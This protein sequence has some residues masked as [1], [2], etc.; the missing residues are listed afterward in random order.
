[1]QTLRGNDFWLA[2]Q[3]I[4]TDPTSWRLSIETSFCESKEQEEKVKRKIYFYFFCRAAIISISIGFTDWQTSFFTKRQKRG[5]IFDSFLD[6]WS[7]WSEL[8]PHKPWNQL[9]KLH[10]AYSFL[11]ALFTLFW[12]KLWNQSS[13]SMLMAWRDF[14]IESGVFIS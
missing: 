4:A 3:L 9:W 10:F 11:E 2:V 8:G 14:C 5:F 12:A 7:S 13:H 1:M 6:C